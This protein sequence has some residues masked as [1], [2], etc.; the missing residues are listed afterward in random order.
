MNENIPSAIE[1]MPEPGVQVDMFGVQHRFTPKG[2][3]Q[4]TQISMDDQL[5]LEILKKEQGGK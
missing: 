3:G 4:V 1:G 5:K 2:R